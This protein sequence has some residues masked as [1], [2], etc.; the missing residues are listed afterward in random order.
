MT[1]AEDHFEARFS[2]HVEFP[3]FLAVLKGLSIVDKALLGRVTAHTTEIASCHGT[4]HQ[5]IS[6]GPNH[7]GGIP[8]CPG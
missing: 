8:S 2:S 4:I 3:R 6:T 5:R 1:Q 7:D